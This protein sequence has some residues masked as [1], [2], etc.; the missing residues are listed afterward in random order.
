MPTTKALRSQAR[1]TREG[2]FAAPAAMPDGSIP[3]RAARNAPVAQLD[4]APDYEIWGSEVRNPS[5]RANDFR[6]F[7]YLHP[8]AAK[9]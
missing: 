1:P 2:G 5:G 3:P 7:E 4:R 9:R 8:S 6:V